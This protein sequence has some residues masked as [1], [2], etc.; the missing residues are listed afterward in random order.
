MSYRLLAYD[1]HRERWEAVEAFSHFTDARGRYASATHEPRF[2]FYALV[3]LDADRVEVV[4][5]T[6]PTP[7]SRL[8]KDAAFLAAAR[9]P[10]R[11]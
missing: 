11:V 9:G 7:D 1:R 5:S 3:R 6:A 8:A 10:N 2:K 4:E